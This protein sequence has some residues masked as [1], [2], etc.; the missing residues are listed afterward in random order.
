[1]KI[2]TKNVTLFLYLLVLSTFSNAQ[3]GQ[4]SAPNLDWSLGDFPPVVPT[5][6][7]IEPFNGRSQGDLQTSEQSGE[8]WWYDIV[9][10]TEGGVTDGYVVSG[11]ATWLDVNIKESLVGGVFDKIATGPDLGRPVLD[12][13]TISGKLATVGEYNK[14]G[15]MLWCKGYFT[16]EE[17]AIGLTATSDGGYAFIGWGNT[18]TDLNGNHIHYNPTTTDAGFDLTDQSIATVN[19]K[20]KMLVGKVDADGNLLWVNAYGYYDFSYDIDN[21]TP[22]ANTDDNTALHANIFGTDI[23]EKNGR[24]FITGMSTNVS[25]SNYNVVVM[26]LNEDGKVIQKNMLGETNTTFNAR[27]IESSIDGNS[28]YISGDRTIIGSNKT[29]AV[30]FKLN[31]TGLNPVNFSGYPLFNNVNAAIRYSPN[32]KK[33]VGW[34]VKALPN[35]KVVWGVVEDCEGCLNGGPNNSGP[36]HLF[37]FDEA[38][39][40]PTK[41]I[42]LQ[43][44]NSY[45][46]SK[47]QA[48]DFKIGLT[49]TSNGGFA[50]VT[51]IK[52]TPIETTLQ[53]SIVTDLEN[54]VA[55][56][57]IISQQFIDK[58]WSTDSYVAKFDG[59]GNLLWDKSW[60]AFNTPAELY[61]GD[62]K[63]QECVYSI[64]EDT[65]GGLVLVGNCSKNKDDY[66]LAKILSDCGQHTVFDVFPQDGYISTDQTWNSTTSSYTPGIIKV[67][68]NLTIASGVTLTIDNVTVEFADSRTMF[69]ST[70]IIIEPGGNLVVKNNAKLTSLSNCENSMWDGIEVRGVTTDNTQSYTIQGHAKFENAVVENATVAVRNYGKFE[71]G[72]IDWASRGGI[73]QASNTTFLNNRRDVAFSA[74]QKTFSNGNLANDRSYFR[75][76]DFITDNGFNHANTMNHVTMWKTYGISFIGCNFADNRTG[77]DWTST[78]LKNGNIHNAGIRSVDA[79]YS[80][81]GKCE[82]GPVNCSGDLVTN[83]SGW[84]PTTFKNL[85]FG[86]YA[87]NTSTE[88]AILVDRCEFENNLDGIVMIKTNSATVTRN[89][90]ITNATAN[91]NYLPFTQLS[92]DPST[93]IGINANVMAEF[94]FEENHFTNTGVDN[95]VGIMSANLGE[96]SED[97]YKNYFTNLKY[98]NLTQ[99][100]NRNID[101]TESGEEGLQFLCNENTNNVKDHLV[102][103][104][105]WSDPTWPEFSSDT[106]GVKAEN[107]AMTLKSG[108]QFTQNGAP[109]EDYDNESENSVKYWYDNTVGAEIPIEYS[110]N[111]D[112]QPVLS[113][114]NFCISKLNSYP[115]V[116][117]PLSSVTQLTTE[118]ETVSTELEQKRLDYRALLD[119]GDTD[120]LLLLIANLTPA[121]KSVLRQELLNCSPYVTTEIIKATINNTEVN[122]PNSWG[123][124][125]I[126]ANIDIVRTPNFSQF[127]STKTNPMPQWMLNTI[128]WYI[129]NGISLTPKAIKQSEISLLTYERSFASDMIIRNVKNDTTGTDLDSVKYW[130]EQKGNVDA[131]VRVID[132]YLQKNDLTMAQT[133]V[134]DLNADVLN[135]PAHLQ[136]EI[137]DVVAFKTEVISIMG[138]AG[139]LANMTETQHSFMS[140]MASTGIG[141]ARYQAQE[142]ICFFYDECFKY[143]FNIPE[144]NRTMVTEQPIMTKPEL[145]FKLFPNPA[146]NWVTIELPLDVTPVI[147]TITDL[148]GKLIGNAIINR[149]IYI[150]ETD[151][152]PNGTYLINIKT[153]VGNYE[154][155]TEKVTI[156]H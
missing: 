115:I 83:P 32:N 26:E 125:L 8:D 10:H 107:G 76:V 65:D 35:G 71:N 5:G 22:L 75:D 50:V 82:N 113:N 141:V 15:K 135:Y 48:F 52:G 85:D 21:N 19:K 27:K 146:S 126:L 70:K 72:D 91:N 114:L 9:P 130:I 51:S 58:V 97:I 41:N 3:N 105:L 43:N 80:V 122:Y 99:G 57:D 117:L 156:Q 66:Y 60:D 17:G 28:L 2:L 89:K 69:T 132:I 55:G 79:Q 153:E 36:G 102:L 147:V 124:E 78:Y 131:Q 37:L 98:A 92:T 34:D 111:F 56:N 120:G 74:Y 81:K 53:N 151:H 103:G 154:L 54:K 18:S 96:S 16:A 1:M 149:P 138:N 73:I 88:N 7:I 109:L 24:I 110:A 33:N 93:Q 106:Y 152:L 116:S 136:A 45:N 44:I 104:T 46:F 100:K 134:N 86:I 64:I 4:Y 142:L 108:V 39:G 67:V 29:D 145:N 77:G 127:L 6:A 31:A 112:P 20:S 42:N 90:F 137:Q 123:L 47:I 59:N 139:G 148:Q 121:T 68:G 13:E 30:L 63:E 40:T 128:G 133:K 62:Y 118:F 12:G 49:P 38:G 14:H 150:W 144:A 129:Q 119:C 140:N 61:P 155:G 94:R 84:K 23:I 25:N 95:S 143:S 11:Y 87:A 101:G